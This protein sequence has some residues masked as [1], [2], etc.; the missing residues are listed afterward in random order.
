MIAAP[1]ILSLRD[2]W[3]R[4]LAVAL[5]AAPATV[6]VIA[7][8]LL[9][10]VAILLYSVW[11]TDYVEVIRSPTF[12]NLE[13]LLTDEVVR[14][15]ALRSLWI[16]VV[17]SLAC[18][19]LVYP[20]AYLAAFRV[21]RKALF[22]FA[23]VLPMWVSYIVRA[24]S[25]R[26]ILGEHG[27]LNGFLQAVGLVHR[28]IGAFLFSPLA[29]VITLTHVYLAFAFVPIYSVLDGLP[30][31]ILRAASD[32]Y[33]DPIRRFLR[34]TLPLSAPGVAAAVMFVFPLSFGDYIAPTLVGGPDGVMIANLVQNQF[35]VT[36]DWPYGAAIVLGILG[37]VLVVV[38]AME[39]WRPVEQVNLL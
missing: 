16:G 11:R 36:F 23:V 39:R 3:S 19:V 32:L 4:G 33:A 25:W 14:K 29:V 28:P 26:I 24:Y 27:I 12:E 6:W 13:R 17:V 30:R 9:P 21:Q 34:V 7:F 15:V 38:R 1:D 35:G 37:V 5:F 31:S 10:Y 8:I 20:L 22:V 2:R 18:V